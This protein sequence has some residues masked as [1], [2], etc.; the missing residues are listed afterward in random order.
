MI[1]DKIKFIEI[2]TK[3][4]GVFEYNNRLNNFNE[5]INLIENFLLEKFI[6]FGI[7]IF[8]DLFIIIY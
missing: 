2:I 3:E 6:R 4:T 1:Y 5:L 7:K 8:Y